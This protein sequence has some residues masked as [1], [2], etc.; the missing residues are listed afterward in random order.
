LGVGQ[1]APGGHQLVSSVYT[2]DMVVALD[3]ILPGELGIARLGGGGSQV[4]AQRVGVI[5]AQE[6]GYLDESTAALA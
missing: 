3:E 1:V 4:E 2:Q 5:L 6:V